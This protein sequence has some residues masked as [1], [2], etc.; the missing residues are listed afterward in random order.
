MSKRPVE[1][2]QAA[3]AFYADLDVDVSDYPAICNAYKVGHLMSIDLERICR[4]HDV[5]MADVYLMGA[6]RAEEGVPY[7]PPISRNC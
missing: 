3:S 7:M 4:R 1:Q 5:S 2:Q 6:I